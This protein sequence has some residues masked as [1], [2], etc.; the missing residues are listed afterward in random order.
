MSLTV[1][2]LEQIIKDRLEAALVQV[3]DM[4][5]GCGQ[6]FAVIIVSDVFKG[7][8]KLMRHRIVNKALEQE[9]A[10]IH[11]FT[12][13]GFTVEEWEKQKNDYQ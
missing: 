11:A 2:Y 10:A 1:G 5:G 13:K 12:Q 8:N 6:A 9:I 7:K 3:Q 4:S